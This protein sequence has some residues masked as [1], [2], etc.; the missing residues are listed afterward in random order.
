LLIQLVLAVFIL[1][2]PIGQKI[3]AKIGAMVTKILDFSDKGAEFVFGI[4]VDKTGLEQ[5][6][7][8]VKSFIFYFKIIF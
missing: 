5:V 2:V 4:L 8:T 3:F 7:G 6:F 1:K